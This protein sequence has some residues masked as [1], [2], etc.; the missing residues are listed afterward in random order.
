MKLCY[1]RTTALIIERRA[2]VEKLAV[3]LLEKENLD[4]LDI[5]ELIGERPFPPNETMIEYMKQVQERHEREA[6]LKKEKE[7]EKKSEV[8]S[9]EESKED[10]DDNGR[11][12]DG[13]GIED[14]NKHT[15]ATQ[16]IITGLG[17]KEGVM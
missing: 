2:E 9:K 15:G 4:L 5:I 16:K 1:E 7:L 12:D 8:E 6:E 10:E 14:N 3:A 11:D 17:K 13:N